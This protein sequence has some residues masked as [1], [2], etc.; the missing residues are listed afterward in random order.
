MAFDELVLPF[1]PLD[2]QGICL[3]AK[4]RVAIADMHSLAGTFADINVVAKG[5]DNF[6]SD[7]SPE[8]RRESSPPRSEVT[9][10]EQ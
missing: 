3:G 4:N 6:E 8:M 9:K 1:E 2:I 10:F 5:E 7:P